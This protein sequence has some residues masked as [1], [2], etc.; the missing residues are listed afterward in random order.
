MR[1][2]LQ[3]PNITEQERTPLLESLLT[4][5]EQ[6]HERVRQQDE[7]IQLLKDELRILKGEKKRPTFKPSKGDKETEKSSKADADTK[8]ESKRPGSSKRSKNAELTIHEEKVIQP[9]GTIPPGA[10]VKGYRDFGVQEWVMHPPTIR[11]RL[12]PWETPDGQTLTGQLPGELGGRHYGPHLIGYRLYPHHHCQVTPPLL[13]EQLRE[14]GVDLS[15]GELNPLLSEGKDTFHQEKDALLKTGLAVS[16]YV[17]VDDSGAR[18][19][20]KNGDVTQ[21]GNDHFAW[22]ESTDSKSRINFLELLCAGDKGYRINK[23]TLAYWQQQKLPQ[24]PF[25]LLA[26]HSTGYF[27]DALQGETHRDDL[28]L[29]Q[30]RHRR[31]ATEGALLGNVMHEGRCRSL[32]I[33]SDDAG[34]FNILLQALCWGHAERLIHT[35]LPLN[36][37]HREDIAKVRGD[38]WAFYAE[39]K[40]D[41]DPPQRLKKKHLKTASTP[42][43]L[44][45]RV[46]N[47]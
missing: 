38:V 3:V 27:T 39:L 7:E 26:S 8:K 44:K 5:V 28:G 33:V 9:K 31:I 21:R 37:G 36:E 12:A 30:A 42:F 2:V 19:Q 24:T 1:K 46:I 13:L 32:V 47:Y 14:W 11:Y 6:L 25:A 40:H 23:D 10:R 41:K 20:G 4:I 35:L 18:H 17:T 43:L 45:R 22:F 34:Q 29:S 16:D 15:A